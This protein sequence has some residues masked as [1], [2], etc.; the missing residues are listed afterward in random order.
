[1]HGGKNGLVA[2]KDHPASSFRDETMGR[3]LPYL[4]CFEGTVELE[5]FSLVEIIV[6]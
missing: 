5:L 1:M 6:I 2:G 3:L 4:E